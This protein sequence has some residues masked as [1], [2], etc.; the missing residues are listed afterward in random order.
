MKCSLSGQNTRVLAKAVNSFSRIGSELYLE[1]NQNGLTLRTVNDSQTAFSVMNFE[2]GFFTDFKIDRSDSHEFGN[3]CKV[4][5]KSCLG[6]FKNMRQVEKCQISL[7]VKTSKLLIKFIC[8]FD[9]IKTHNVSILEQESLNAVYMTEN[10]PNRMTAPNKMF[11]EIINNFRMYD[12]EIT[13]EAAADLVVL[14]NNIDIQTDKHLMRTK[15]TLKSQEFSEYHI[16]VPTT[17][18]F[19]L[20]ELRAILNFADALSL[21]MTINFETAG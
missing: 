7:N 5:M 14:K 15:L 4:S 11:T 9:T 3:K 18:T 21:D 10:P 19:C 12:N 6:V 13:I 1:A 2:T 17:I 16:S 8:L 20:K